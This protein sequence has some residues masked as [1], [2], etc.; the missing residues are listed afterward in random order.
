[1]AILEPTTLRLYRSES[2][3]VEYAQSEGYLQV[4]DNSA[5]VLVEEAVE[6][7]EVDTAAIEAKFKDAREALERAE[8]DSEE[9][10]R[11]ERDLKRWEAFLEVAKG[12]RD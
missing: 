5:L 10:R 12:E 3:V 2:E 9:K 7:G 8:D 6:P 4:V 1:M 11:A